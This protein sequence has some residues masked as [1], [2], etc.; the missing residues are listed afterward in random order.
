MAK[1]IHIK[2]VLD[3]ICKWNSNNIQTDLNTVDKTYLYNRNNRQAFSLFYV[4]ILS[5]VLTLLTSCSKSK[6]SGNNTINDNLADQYRSL[7]HKEFLNKASLYDADSKYLIIVDY[8]IPSNKNRLFVWDCEHD[9]IVAKFWCAH[10]FGGNSTAEKPEFS[11]I[12]GSNCSSLGWFL[13][14][15]SVGVS[16]RWGY[17]YHAVDGLESIN[18]NARRREILIH[19][20]SSVSHDCDAKIKNPMEL[21][22][23]S[24]GCFTTSDKGFETID[25]Y[26]KSRQKR[27]LLCAIN[28]L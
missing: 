24:A 1:Y 14:D 2:T 28:G 26:I 3:K 27:L 7:V 12:I 20:W 8:S 4:C 16:P 9:S 10:G 6:S 19:P 17:R 21:D 13:V 15:K 23:R 25:S 18:S 11:N 22:G 5:I